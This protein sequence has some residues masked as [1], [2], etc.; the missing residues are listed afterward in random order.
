MIARMKNGGILTGGAAEVF[1]R[2][3][4]AVEISQD[5]LKEINVAKKTAAESRKFGGRP[6]GATNKPKGNKGNAKSNYKKK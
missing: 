5:D 3:G 4:L 2:I 1:A 6:K